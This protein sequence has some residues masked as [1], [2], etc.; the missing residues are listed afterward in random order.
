MARRQNRREQVSPLRDWL[1]RY[2]PAALLV[3]AVAGAYSNS[4]QGEFVFDDLAAIRDNTTIRSLWPPGGMLS[5]PGQGTTVDGRPLL[6][7]SFALN[8]A[9]GGDDVVGYHL[10]NLAIHLAASLV[11]FGLIRRTLLLPCFSVPWRE[12]ATGLALAAA[13]LWAIHPLQT[14]SVTYIVQRAESLAGLLLLLTLYGFVRSAA[15]DAASKGWLAASWLC[16]LLGMA[17]KETMAAAPLLV[18]LYD[19]AFLAGSWKGAIRTR[20]RV[21]AA[22]MATWLLL[23][24]LVWQSA[25]RGGTAGFG[26]RT[27]PGRYALTQLPAILHYLRLSVW[28]RPLVM[29]YGDGLVEPG[30]WLLPY[31]LAVAG[32]VFVTLLAIW[33][34][35]KPGFVGAWFWCLLA[36]TSSIVPVITQTVAEHRMYLPLAAVALL[37]V[38]AGWRLWLKASGDTRERP[39]RLP[40]F[41]PLLLLA[42]AVSALSAQTRLRNLD[43]RTRLSI[44]SDTANK[45]P[46]NARALASVGDELFELGEQKLALE[47]VTQAISRKPDDARLLCGRADMYKQLGDQHGARSE[48]DLARQNLRRAADDYSAALQIDPRGADLWYKRAL[49]QHRLGAWQ[50]AV[51]DYTQA[52]ALRP[53]WPEAL[54]NRADAHLR[55]RDYGSAWQDVRQLRELGAEPIPALLENLIR[56]SGRLQP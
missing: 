40:R 23:A 4:F 19:R 41:V 36:P 6:N 22:L 38:V 27:S 16:C 55:L 49:A 12:S 54:N 10:T 15:S 52:L 13:L 30:W 9:I 26:P 21:H 25:G 20:W 17:A 37:A 8:W 45:V 3:L 34:W 28:P 47:F 29:D 5:P 46:H 56:E 11:L 48:M 51:G 1:R 18:L 14:E 31:G 43:Y 53:N 24:W 32:M 42:A 50:A 35:P 39:A 33:R 44:W 2:W 7:V